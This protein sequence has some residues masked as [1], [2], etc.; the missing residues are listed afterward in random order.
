[1]VYPCYFNSE[2]GLIIG[3]FVCQPRCS[4]ISHPLRCTLF[5]RL[6][7]LISPIH[8]PKPFLISQYFSPVSHI[9]VNHPVF[10]T[11]LRLFRSHNPLFPATAIWASRLKGHGNPDSK[12]EGWT[13][14]FYNVHCFSYSHNAFPLIFSHIAARLS[15]FFSFHHKSPL[16]QNMT[17]TQRMEFG[18]LIHDGGKSL[19]HYPWQSTWPLLFRPILPLPAII[20]PLCVTPFPEIRW[21]LIYPQFRKALK[22]VGAENVRLRLVPAEPLKNDRVNTVAWW[23]ISVCLL[24][25][26]SFASSAYLCILCCLMPLISHI[27][28]VPISLFYAS[29][30]SLDHRNSRVIVKSARQ[31]R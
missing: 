27:S 26:S 29:S 8:S 16:D 19:R 24:S 30:P 14:R 28:F 20:F 6:S 7:I 3:G 25:L 9:R 22:D 4:S 31:E 18:N 17:F 13:L 12:V 21:P 15:F 1:M 11:M 10:L 2:F 23:T 5:I